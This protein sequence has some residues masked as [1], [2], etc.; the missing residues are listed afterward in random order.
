[1]TTP[2]DRI[3]QEITENCYVVIPH[4]RSSVLIGIVT[5]I[6]PKMVNVKV[7]DKYGPGEILK[8]QKEVVVLPITEATMYALVNPGR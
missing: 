5:R 7:L 8:K 1:M 3:G 2:A 4:S 6:T